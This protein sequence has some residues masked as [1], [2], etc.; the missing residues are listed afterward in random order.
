MEVD[1]PA[2]KL[3]VT[4]PMLFH[5]SVVCSL[6]YKLS[7]CVYALQNQKNSELTPYFIVQIFM[8]LEQKHLEN[9]QKKY[10]RK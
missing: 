6:S 2:L 10:K 4:S 9:G 1:K 5:W 8:S 3:N 7:L